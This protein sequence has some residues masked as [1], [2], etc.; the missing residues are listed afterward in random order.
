AGAASPQ[1]VEDKCAASDKFSVLQ[2]VF[3]GLSAVSVG[4]GTYLL[5]TEKPDEKGPSTANQLQVLP[6]AVRGGGGL[7]LRLKF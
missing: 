1:T 5:V 7:D 4:A 2:W 6:T 3:Y